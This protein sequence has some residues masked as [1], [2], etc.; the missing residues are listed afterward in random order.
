MPTIS[1]Q[2]RNQLFLLLRELPLSDEPWAE[3]HYWESLRSSVL[4][5]LGAIE[6]PI[7]RSYSGTREQV[8]VYA[9]SCSDTELLDLL[10]IALSCSG[11]WELQ[12]V[13]DEFAYCIND[14][15]ATRGVGY[16]LTPQDRDQS[17]QIV[18]VEETVSYETAI[19]PALQAL[20]S[21]Q[22][23]AADQEFRTALQHYRNS[24]FP[25]CI[26][27]CG[28][29]MESVLVVIAQSRGW[30]IPGKGKMGI[31]FKSVISEL[32]I[33]P[34]Y[35][36]PFDGVATLRGQLSSAHGGGVKPRVVSQRD[37][38]YM[39]AITAATIALVIDSNSR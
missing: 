13:F 14:V 1:Q 27:W 23:A 5:S 20:A 21:E 3:G 39:L 34:A 7:D 29:A 25:D 4:H 24:R 6:L 38:R 19:E 18:V 11:S 35:Q 8:L 16:R 26:T 22:F 36:K 12:R 33:P 37:A 32:G 15:F 9:H 31:L 17:P 10:E 30:K 28:N 2:T